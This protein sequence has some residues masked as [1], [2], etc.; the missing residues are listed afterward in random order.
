MSFSQTVKEELS[1]QKPGALHCRIAELT[2]MISMCGGVEVSCRD[3]FCL[4]IQTENLFVARKS[5]TLLKKTFNI[6]VEL[7]IRQYRGARSTRQYLV[8]VR[9]HEDTV[10]ILQAAGM[11]KDGGQSYMDLAE[12]PEFLDHKLLGRTCC[13]RAFLR[14]A[15]L[16]TGSVSD[17]RKFYHLEFSCTSE[18]KAQ[19]VQRVLQTFGLEARVVPRKRYFVVYLK[20][21]DGIVDVLNIIEAHQALMELENIRIVKEVRNTLNRKVNCET[22]NICKTVSA[23][24]KQ[25]ED[26]NFIRD[27]VGFEELP[28]SLSQMAGVR[29]ENP[30]ATLKEL[31]MLLSPQVGKSGVNH[32]LRKLSEIAEELRGNKEEKHY[33]KKKHQ[34]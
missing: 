17:P 16:V 34:N 29:L 25:I 26:I 19:R 5:F 10:R 30:D 9:K 6:E 12:D 33:D 14:G 27:T 15:F 24:V 7:S 2:A 4:R 8:W 13:R 32:R 31:G 23:A 21:G 28:E 22:A 20:E 11:I 1:R 18:D 3:R